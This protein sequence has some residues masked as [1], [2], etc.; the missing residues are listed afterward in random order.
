[1]TAPSS[2]ILLVGE[3]GVG[4]THYGAQLLRRLMKG[5]DL[6]R[7][8]GAATNV[9]P[10]EAALDSLNEGRAAE[11][12][13]TA[14]YVDSVWPVADAKGRRA[15]LVWPDYGGEQIKT[16]IE[17]RRVPAAWQTRINTTGAWL[18]LIRLQQT[19][20]GDD[21]FSKPLRDL[22][23]TSMKNQE[24]LPSDQARLVELLQMLLFAGGLS[25]QTNRMP[26]LGVLLTCWDEAAFDGTP[27][28]ALGARLPLVSSFVRSVWQSPLIMGLSALERPL[29]PTAR[30]MDYVAQGPEHFG[31]VIASDGTRSNDLTAPIFAMLN[32][33]T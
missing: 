33:F 3:S 1:M 4:K 31:Y 11:H 2:S 12:T 21:I 26:R 20:I 18:L 13:P 17:S 15:D 29:S 25:G 6:L 32:T 24:V 30:D 23:G 22:R 7:M 27:E 10:F 14:T 5:D 9:E 16:I 8:D 28:E 19:R